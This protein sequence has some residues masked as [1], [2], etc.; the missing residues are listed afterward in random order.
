LDAAL[1]AILE[2]TRSKT[3]HEITS[4]TASVPSSK[5]AE[6]PSAG[7]SRCFKAALLKKYDGRLDVA[8]MDMVMNPR[9]SS[10]GLQFCEF[11]AACRKLHLFV[12]PRQAFDELAKG[13][14][15]IK[16]EDVDPS[17]PAKLRKLKAEQLSAQQMCS[18]EESW[19]LVGSG[20]MLSWQ[21]TPSEMKVGGTAP[22]PWSVEA[23]KATMVQNYGSL[24]RA[25]QDFDANNDGLLHFGE[26]L[27]GCRRL[28]TNCLGQSQARALFEEIAGPGAEAIAPAALDVDMPLRLKQLQAD[29]ARQETDQAKGKKQGL[30][31]DTAGEV[32]WVLEQGLLKDKAPPPSDAKSFKAALI[33]K[34]GKLE[35][36]WEDMDYNGD[37]ALQFYEFISACRRIQFNGNLRKIFDELAVD[38]ELRMED[39][40][41]ILRRA[42]AAAEK[43]A[44][45]AEQERRA[46]EQKR[47]DYLRKNMPKM[48]RHEVAQH[49]ME[50]AHALFK[51]M[52]RE[53]NIVDEV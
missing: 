43:A 4:F 30:C 5:S 8:W 47:Q 32:A 23:L 15:E 27:A 51:D 26:F 48:S 45:R 17:L 29:G 41:P 9:R 19:S 42:K 28:R 46:G 7:G 49:N 14:K 20:S 2:K 33:K 11:L 3:L 53:G 35:H 24:E 1:P 22:R 38:G 36:A 52:L 16:P 34:Y 25:W 18:P 39:M 10:D 13:G 50:F 21:L 37:G 12:N 31:M 44:E 40:D 6:Q